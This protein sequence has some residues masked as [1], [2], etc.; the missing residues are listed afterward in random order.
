[1]K[2]IIVRTLLST[3]LATSALSTSVVI[4]P[5]S[6]QAV[7]QNIFKKIRKD[8]GKAG[9]GI[10]KELKKGPLK[11]ILPVVGTI[12]IANGIAD[13]SPAAIIFG[14]A[15]IA[16]PQTF[17]QD[18]A[19]K[20]G[21]EMQYSGCTNCGNKRIV[22]QPGQTI[23][24]E[25]EKAIRAE[26]KEDIKDVQRALAKF[27]YYTSKIDGDYGKG[28]R[29]AA[30]KFQAKIGTSQTGILN[31]EERYLLFTEAAELGYVRAERELQYEPKVIPAVLTET[32][33]KA[34]VIVTPTIAE[35]R[36]AKSQFSKFAKD[37]LQSG[38]QS[39]VNSAELL[40]DG[41]IKLQILDEL[42]NQS[43]ELTGTIA[44]IELAPHRVSDLWIRVTYEDDQTAEPINLN[45]RD[46][47]DTAEEASAWM[48][49]ADTK[50]RVLAE[51][52]EVP[53]KK[54]EEEILVAETPDKKPS[55]VKIAVTNDDLPKVKVSDDTDEIKIADKP[56]NTGPKIAQPED[57]DIEV[58]KIA[59]GTIGEEK[60]K[61]IALN[62][63]EPKAPVIPEP[64]TISV[65][66]PE[67]L[68]TCRQNLFVNFDFPVEDELVSHFI[69]TPP[70][71]SVW[72]D[73]GDTTSN[74]IGECVQGTYKYE[75]VSITK[76]QSD[77]DWKDTKFT[78][79]FQ[80]ASNAE[81]CSIDLDDPT[82]SAG[83][84]CF[85]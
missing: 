51:L 57:K 61:S 65:N 24:S 48:K 29:R 10:R 45:T 4:A 63:P 38:D 33:P 25:R 46:D 52:T 20:Y 6:S 67:E 74:I 14:A 49:K 7:S 32:E 75:Y 21:R 59:E 11:Q 84:R 79:E 66:A 27:G 81:S 30:R 43:T 35:F 26:I 9:K 36:L 28:S 78:G 55:T 53:M 44:G 2:K 54:E 58:A 13:G 17:Q 69:I 8:L 73:R 56:L 68:A 70:E 3:I 47:F 34:P 18:M 12:L 31:A 50:I 83:V 40:P 77:A 64:T 42:T 16:A 62:P 22:L 37:F 39:I 71:G 82:G 41:R 19:R 85:Q 15:L 60:P 72:F 5:E 1:M 23:T 80:I 76:G